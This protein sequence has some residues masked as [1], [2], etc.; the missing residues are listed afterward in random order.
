MV[1]EVV[2]KPWASP[3]VIIPIT[4]PAELT[5]APPESPGLMAASLWIMP[6]RV[7]ER[8]LPSLAVMVWSTAVT[9]PWVTAGV[10]P[11]PSALPRATTGSPTLT[12]EASASV[13]VGRPDTP[14]I[15]MSATSEVGETP[16]TC[17]G[18]VPVCP[19]IVTEMLID[20][21]TTVLMSTI[22]GSTL[23]AI[24][25]ALIVPFRLADG[26]TAAMG[27]VDEEGSLVRGSVAV[28][29]GW[30]VWRYR[31]TVRPM[32]MPPPAAR[33]VAAMVPTASQRPHDGRG[34]GAGA[35]TQPSGAGGG[36]GTS[37]CGSISDIGSTPILHSVGCRPRCDPIV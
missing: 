37:D 5:S 26:V 4:W 31:D 16:I 28:W 24:A 14:S 22:A 15:W 1:E 3:A 30:D 6:E 13:T 18:E 35:E 34:A 20:W 33:M 11:C 10:P 27:A 32:P 25:A 7:S 12:L 19:A 21:S 23:A 17:A 36:G 29:A 9:W 2:R 8:P